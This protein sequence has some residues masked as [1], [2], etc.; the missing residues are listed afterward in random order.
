MD[1]MITTAPSFD[2]V[3][4]GRRSI[5]RFKPEPEPRPQMTR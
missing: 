2:D 5:R 1:K 4:M 3:V